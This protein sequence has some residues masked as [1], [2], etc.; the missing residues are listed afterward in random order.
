MLPTLMEIDRGGRY[1]TEPEQPE[2]VF[3][4]SVNQIFTLIP[5]FFRNCSSFEELKLDF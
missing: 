1:T 3:P 5:Y 2:S 4:M